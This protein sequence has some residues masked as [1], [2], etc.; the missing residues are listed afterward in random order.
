MG[1]FFEKALGK[2]LPGKPQELTA[3][4][5]LAAF[6][7]HPGWDDHI[8]DM[9][10]D[11]SRLVA[12]KRVLYVQ[13]V[14]GNID[15][16]AWDT[17]EEADRL[18]GF[19]HIFVWRTGSD[20]VVG[21]MWSSRDG[22]GRTRYPMVVCA[23]CANLPLQWAITHVLPR[24]ETIQQRCVSVTAAA[25]VR[26]IIA[27][28]R[29]QLRRLARQAQPVADPVPASPRALAGLADRPEMAPDHQGVHRIIYQ[30]E[31]EMAAYQARSGD[32]S[33]STAR[34]TLL[35]SH[36]MRVPRCADAPEQAIPLWLGFL[37]GQLDPSAPMLLIL[38]LDQPWL[39]IIV[40]EP[41]VQQLYCVRASLK[42]VPLATDIPYSLDDGFVARVETWI[43]E[44]RGSEAAP[45]PPPEPA[46]PPAPPPEPQP[47]PAPA[48]AAPPQPHAAPPAEPSPA[49]A[50]APRP[51]A[52]PA[53][54]PA[55][56]PAALAAP[57]LARRLVRLW[58]VFALIVLAIIL[59]LVVPRL[60]SE[61][62]RREEAPPPAQQAFVWQP[63]HAAAWRELCT[64]YNQWFGRFRSDLTRKQRLERW[65]SDP[66]LA[67]L[68]VKKIQHAA[69]IVIDP[70]RIA[71]QEGGDLEH[72]AQ[73]PPEEAKNQKAVQRT[74]EALDAVKAIAEGI[75]QWP[76]AGEMAL[77]TLAAQYA[78]RGWHDQ[79]KQLQAAAKAVEPQPGAAVAAAIDAALATKSRAASVEAPFRKIDQ[80]Q[81][82]IRILG[83]DTAVQVREYVLAQA[84]AAR[85]L[86]GL[87][88]RLTEGER[89]AAGIA[90][91]SAQIRAHEKQIADAG[92]Q[93][94][95]AKFLECVKAS[96]VDA[97][98]LKSLPEKLDYVKGIA[99]SIAARL[100]EIRAYHDAI[101]ALGD[102]PL[103][104]RLMDCA[105]AEAVTATGL[106]ALHEKLAY[107]K[108]LAPQVADRRKQLQQHLAAIK[109]LGDDVVTRF[110]QHLEASARN[111][112]DTKALV[113]SVG[114]AAA[115][116]EQVAER[117][118]E[119]QGLQRTI[120]G[121][122]DKILAQFGQYVAAKVRA[123]NDVAELPL[124]MN[125]L[126]GVKAVGAQ[127]AAA[128]QGDWEAGRID[129]KAFATES[130]VHRNFAGAVSDAT[131]E[132]WRK[133]VAAYYKLDP[134]TDPRLPPGAWDNAMADIAWRIAFL[135]ESADAA[136]K[137]RGQGCAARHKALEARIQAVRKLPWIKKHQAQVADAAKT[138][139]AE[140]GT[141]EAEL[142]DVIEPPAQWLKRVRALSEIASSNAV[143]QEWVKRRNDLVTDKV[144]A[145]MLRDFRKLY[146][147]LWRGARTLREFLAGLDDPKHL[148]KGPPDAARKLPQNAAFQAMASAIAARR[149]VAVKAAIAAIPWG[150]DKFSPSASALADFKHKDAWKKACH[151]YAAWRQ[152]A[153]RLLV[154]FRTIESLLDAGYLLD[155]K[156]QGAAHAVGQLY[157]QWKGQ[158]V[159]EELRKPL[160]PAIARV[161][162][163]IALKTMN[164]Q[165]LAARAKALESGDPPEAA[166]ALWQ[167]LGR[168]GDWPGTLDELKAEQTLRDR[169]RRLADALRTSNAPRAN[170][171]AQEL[172]REGPKRWLACFDAL[173][174]R[175]T[176]DDLEDK[177]I[178]GALGAVKPFQVQVEKLPAVT[179]L[180][181]LVHRFRKQAAGLPD[182]ARHAA[183]ASAIAAFHKQVAALPDVAKSPPV[184]ALV[185]QLGQ[186]AKEKG[187]DKPTAGLAKAGPMASPVGQEWEATVDK[188]GKWAAYA[189]TRRP[190]SL[191]FVRIEPKDKSAKP[192]Y[193]CTTEVSIG[194]FIDMM[195]AAERWREVGGLLK[196]Y[197]PQLQPIKGPRVWEW[198]A[199]GTEVRIPQTWLAG[200]S[201]A[202]RHYAE[203]L[204]PGT[205][206]ARH[207]MQYVSARAALYFARLMGC[208][209]PTPSEW[210]AA[211]EAHGKGGGRNLRDATWQKQ[212]DHVRKKRE[213]TILIEWP[214][215]GI[216]R[217][218]DVKPSTGTAATVVVKGN[219]GTLWFEPVGSP[220][221][222]HHLVGNVAEFVLDCAPQF[223]ERLKKLADLKTSTIVRFLG[224]HATALGVVGASALSPSE[225]WN[226]SDKPFDKAWKTKPDEAADG[227]ADVGF[228]LAFT[229]PRESPAERL[230]RVLRGHGYLTVSAR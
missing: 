141:F 83:D 189:W 34:T 65:R 124:Y 76:S 206:S 51:A 219:D 84:R 209:L 3:E 205:P 29:Q 90:R 137:K 30:I 1:S 225:L 10:L 24:L 147:K 109:G 94:F 182:D 38:P 91:H 230:K 55:R 14:G 190:H 181:V 5:H 195:G 158:Q 166:L 201:G 191:R 95:A 121:S 100:R 61:R 85:D 125:A 101:A 20:L 169:V 21:R 60:L 172:A 70:R 217:P 157:D 105:R 26:A 22:K 164:R 152:N 132:A 25:D 228:R 196:T 42:A 103:A 161:E 198:K 23:H 184:R 47:T 32:A 208:R 202:V 220:D 2:F 163:L 175:V 67:E 149:E 214:D 92:G 44:S 215:T 165:Q 185:E 73:N 39:E 179:R 49:P 115:L 120:E 160:T 170:W 64:A 222:F 17:A 129:R 153:G 108:T 174:G 7:K 4:V 216:F 110:T 167:R 63:E 8:E 131:L 16:G 173:V 192:A 139:S 36:H 56:A 54:R 212:L 148:P 143:N 87:F 112:R 69:R 68:V 151:D 97:K 118:R 177:D 144:T 203:G 126:D 180:R 155:G 28:H 128:V 45:A 227:Y 156:P 117:W 138:L 207:P 197:D 194:L 62:T 57:A 111:V 200:E 96:T 146:A 223:D 178:A 77:T 130:S 171:L 210:K 159:F 104:D 218:P 31:R 226:G 6:G 99:P 86:D 81:Q 18:E 89:L 106:M 33:S 199:V 211:F 213:Q 135:A 93:A 74:T 80:Y 9:D 50:P 27:E 183:V 122:G 43:Q 40:G 186:V 59:A 142:K 107:V 154:D 12:T 123:Q 19:S 46:P 37:L 114:D 75:A 15:S 48:P 136:K 193:L 11:S 224:Q 134:K 150:N 79:A 78:E 176:A 113:Q 188:D 13:G 127:L 88:A 58:P 52:A 116:A 140:L 71:D 98:D 72:M 119:V 221:A 41:G 66:E 82:A 187:P 133:E 53:P 168:K 145:K 229:A 204:D 162:G 35:R 102:K